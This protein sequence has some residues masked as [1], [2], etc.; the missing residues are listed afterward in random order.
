MSTEKK[1]VNLKS[2]TSEKLTS[3]EISGVFYH[4]LNKLLID[5]CDSV[6]PK[7]LIYTMAKLKAERNIDKDDFAFNLETLMM[8]LRT[9][10]QA[11]EDSGQTTSNDVEIDMPDIDLDASDETEDSEG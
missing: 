3:I 11:F 2:I 7:K 4:R 10:E 1:K 8:L 6:A 5:Y 9:V